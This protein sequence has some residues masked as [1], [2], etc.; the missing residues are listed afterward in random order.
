[1]CSKCAAR[2]QFRLNES[3]ISVQ[4]LL[5]ILWVALLGQ[6]TG[7]SPLNVQTKN[8]HLPHSILMN[9]QRETTSVEGKPRPKEQNTVKISHRWATVWPGGRKICRLSFY[10][11]RS[12]SANVP[13]SLK[14]CLPQCEYRQIPWTPLVGFEQQALVHTGV[15]KV[16][17]HI[18]CFAFILTDGSSPCWPAWGRVRLIVCLLVYTGQQSCGSVMFSFYT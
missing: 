16:N 14:W 11:K 7:W 2:D 1:M 3:F 9:E 6:C 13:L 5:F 18:S 15:T 8:I 12:S 10:A 17:N 4:S